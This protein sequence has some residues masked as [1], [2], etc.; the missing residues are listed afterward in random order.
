MPRTKKFTEEERKQRALESARRWRERNPEHRRTIQAN[1]WRANR[2]RL[3]DY[4][5]EYQ[6][7]NLHQLQ[8]K[9]REYYLNVVKPRLK[10]RL[11]A[12]N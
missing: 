1:Y 5:R 10:A 4:A 3:K 7:K 11:E 9:R 6:A 2:E 8:V 12:M